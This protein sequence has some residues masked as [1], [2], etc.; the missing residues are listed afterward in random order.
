MIWQW[1]YF[2]KAV[3]VNALGD[4]RAA[5]AMCDQNIAILRQLVEQEGRDD[6]SGDMMTSELYR[7]VVLQSMNPLSVAD[8]QRAKAAFV[9]LRSEIERNGSVHLQNVLKWAQAN[10]DGIV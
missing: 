5:V 7:A 8:C 3:A 6:L 2:G 10:L 9:G 4:Y 1:F